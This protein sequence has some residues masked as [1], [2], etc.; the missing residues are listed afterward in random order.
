MVEF[1]RAGSDPDDLAGEFEPT[2]RSIRNWIARSDKKEG[3]HPRLLLQVAPDWQCP[4]PGD[5]AALLSALPAQLIR[6]VCAA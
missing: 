6:P 4:L 1:P 2:A 3:R 5:G